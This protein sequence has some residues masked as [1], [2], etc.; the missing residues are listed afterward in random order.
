[1]C[2]AMQGIMWE[3]QR[4]VRQFH[5]S[6]E[7]FWLHNRTIVNRNMVEFSSWKPPMS[8]PWSFLNACG[9]LTS[10]ILWFGY[11]LLLSICLVPL[12]HTLLNIFSRYSLFLLLN[13][14]F[15]YKHC[16]QCIYRLE[17]KLLMI[18]AWTLYFC[19]NSTCGFILANHVMHSVPFPIM[20]SLNSVFGY[21]NEVSSTG[22]MRFSVGIWLLLFTW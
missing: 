19:W 14:N 1:L 2:S 13:M 21:N 6:A 5:Q 10:L 3:L 17:E 22:G 18:V 11:L 8:L 4:K 15:M 7:T 20:C 12:I 9:S 16:R